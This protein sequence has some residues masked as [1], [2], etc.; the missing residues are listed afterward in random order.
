MPLSFDEPAMVVAAPASCTLLL[1]PH[2]GRGAQ[3][4]ELVFR[5]GLFI[6]EGPEVLLLLLKRYGS[7]GTRS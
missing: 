6:A 4:A 3:D 1:R 2:G 7:W 5:R